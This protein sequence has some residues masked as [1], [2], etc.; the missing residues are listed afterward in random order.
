MTAI[1]L[2]QGPHAGESLAGQVARSLGGRVRPTAGGW[3][4]DLAQ[5]P[6]P[7]TLEALRAR[8]RCDLNLLPPHFD[9]AAVRLV[10]SDMDSTFIAIECIDEIADFAGLKPQVAAITAAAMRGEI[11]FETSLKR[12][13]SLLAGLPVTVLEQVYRERLRLSPG[14]EALVAGLH[15]RDIAFALVSGGFTFFTER[16]RRRLGLDFTLANE[17]EI[18]DGHLTGRVLGDIVGAAAKA[19]FLDRLCE[20]LQIHP[21]QTIA[22]GDGANDLELLRRAGLAVAYHAKPALQTAADVVLD[23][24]DLEAVL[25]LLAP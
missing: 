17:L 18:E 9:P 22:I 4:L 14:A 1:L 8:H 12:R 2:L 15:E 7:E 11:D 16:L 13:V 3:Q 25:A 5:P 6:A 24:S 23:H 10:V 21:A 19:A 20:R